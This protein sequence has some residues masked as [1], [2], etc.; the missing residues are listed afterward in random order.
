[1]P[2]NELGK[3]ALITPAISSTAELEARAGR[4]WTAAVECDESLPGEGPIVGV[5]GLGGTE[6][7]PNTVEP[8]V[9]PATASVD[10]IG[11]K[12]PKLPVA[13]LSAPVNEK[14]WMV[15]VSLDEHKIVEFSLKAKQ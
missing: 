10:V 11:V 14:K 13:E 8:K 6:A 1:M 4:A 5:I 7:E 9:L 12:C 2:E 3:Y 15:P